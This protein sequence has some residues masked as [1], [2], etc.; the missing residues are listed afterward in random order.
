[1]RRALRSAVAG[2]FL[3]ALATSAPAQELAERLGAPR[4]VRE[5]VL[6]STTDLSVMRPVIEA[7]LETRPGVAVRYEQWLSNNLYDVTRADCAAGGRAADLVISSAV[8]HM[9]DLVNQ[10]CATRH[11][12]AETAALPAALGWRDE[13]WGV[14]REPAVMVYNRDL[15]PPEDVPHSRFDL[16]DLLRDDDRPYAGRVATYDI[17]ASGL[18]YLFAYADSLE[19]TTFG[20]LMEAFG[21]ADTVA[22]CCSAE[23]MAGVL[24]GDYLIAYN[25]IG[26]YALE[27]A[28]RTPRL[29]IVAPGDYTLILSRGA[30]IPKGAADGALGAEMVDFLLSPAGRAALGAADLLTD[31]EDLVASGAV[32]VDAGPSLLRPVELSPKLLVASDR[33]KRM[34]FSARWRAAF[35]Q[36]TGGPAADR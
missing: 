22:T 35:P 26:S 6:R 23:I 25:I 32:D 19:A 28:A 15:V 1:M 2:L 12:S 9:V 27:L 14:T 34:L 30:M 10:G 16:L 21:R 24:A 17:E 4:A 13:L 36:A 5:M 8:H 29:G 7:F 33:Q 31:L 20:G 18:G 3:A 11:V